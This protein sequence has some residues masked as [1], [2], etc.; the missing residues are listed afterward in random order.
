MSDMGEHLHRMLDRFPQVV[1]DQTR[2]RGHGRPARV[3]DSC[4]VGKCAP[5]AREGLHGA[6]RHD[7]MALEPHQG[8]V[9]IVMRLHHEFGMPNAPRARVGR[10]GVRCKTMSNYPLLL[11]FQIFHSKISPDQD[12]G[13]CHF[14]I[15][16]SHGAQQVFVVAGAL[17][18]CT[19]TQV[20]GA[21][22]AARTMLG[23]G[24]KE[25]QL[26]S[27]RFCEYGC[28]CEQNLFDFEQVT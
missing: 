18:F 26:A 5:H 2:V 28:T 4:D 11:R 20:H 23:A 1:S 7:F 14:R 24:P 15:S 22:D 12:L 8:L 10:A 9:H 3:T 21:V 13:K 25:P 17:L 6:P 19:V 16:P 27:R